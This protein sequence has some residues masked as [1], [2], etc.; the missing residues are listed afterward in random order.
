MTR[1]PLAMKFRDIY[2][3]FRKEQKNHGFDEQ[4]VC[5][6]PQRSIVN[7]NGTSYQDN[8][9]SP[10]SSI[11]ELSK[12]NFSAVKNA[13]RI[14]IV[15][16]GLAG[17][18]CAYRLKQ[19][20][21]SSEIY[22]ASNRVGG[23]CYTRRGE[24]DQQQIVEAGGEVIDSD[25]TDIL[26]LTHEL[27][28]VLDDLELA[29]RPDTNAFYY[30]NGNHYLHTDVIQDLKKVW[31]KLHRDV[32]AAGYPTLYNRYTK[33]GWELDHMSIVDWINESVSG[34]VH[35]NFGKLLELAYT[36]EYG[37]EAEDQS[38]LNLLY[39]L[40][41]ANGSAD[42]RYRVRGGNDQIAQKLGELM[43]NQIIYDTPLIAIKQRND[44]TFVLSFQNGSNIKDVIADKVVLALPF[45]IL[46]SAVDFSNAGFRSLKGLSI[47]ELGVAKN[48][49]V[50]LQ[51]IDRHWETLNCNGETYSDTGYQYTY[52]V[53]RAQAGK[54]G[55]LVN[56]CGGNICSNFNFDQPLD[57]VSKLVNQQLEPVLPG[58]SPK[59]NGKATID[60]W[61]E[62]NWTRGSNSYWKVGQYT[63]FSGI[64]REPE[65]HCHFA[66]EH[67]SIDFQG[68][69]NGAVES[70]ERAAKEILHDLKGIGNN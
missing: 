7:R 15:G 66:G 69:M 2:S 17:L 59:W 64:E 36:S 33:R 47:K 10:S 28:F 43:S 9:A 67:T 49:K 55:I 57:H 65:G 62:Y 23:R 56:Y 63:K 13:P 70:G 42:E 45:S 8:N 6:Y 52:E 40:V 44:G 16:A 50:N 27:G 29:E 31:K 18:T 4:F 32:K 14:I 41:M 53:T 58:I 25:H 51:F 19:A 37:A 46:K 11:L 61:P 54:S 21:F 22:E 3:N 1:T 24:F 35:S 20:G 48:T 38:S 12:S 68:Y 60:H 34:G 26:Q 39:L 5:Q 30:V